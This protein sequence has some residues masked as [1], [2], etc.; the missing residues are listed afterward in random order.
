M[1]QPPQTEAD[2]LQRDKRSLWT[3]SPS[4]EAMPSLSHDLTSAVLRSIR[5]AVAASDV[6][7]KRFEAHVS[8]DAMKRSCG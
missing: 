7:T 6:E 5:E 3:S 2:S 1:T 8:D 4:R